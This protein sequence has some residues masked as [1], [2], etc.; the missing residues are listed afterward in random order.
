MII[1]SE[2]IARNVRTVSINDSPFCT[3][4]V[5]ALTD[6]TSAPNIFPA[7]SNEARVRVEGSKKRFTIVYPLRAGTRG[8]LRSR[9]SRIRS[10]KDN[11]VVISVCEKSSKSSTL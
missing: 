10:A 4:E 1:A 8:I 3:E 11:T 6:I 2:R 7:N 5:D 9:I